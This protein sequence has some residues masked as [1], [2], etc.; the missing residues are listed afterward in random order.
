VPAQRAGG[1]VPAV[2]RLNR[3]LNVRLAKN[4][5]GKKIFVLV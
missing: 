3:V 1:G 4:R 2:L 5:Q